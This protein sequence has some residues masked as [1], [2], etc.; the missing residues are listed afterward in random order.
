MYQ[1]HPEMDI[2]EVVQNIFLVVDPKTGK[3][4]R[5]SPKKVQLEGSYTSKMY[6]SSYDNRVVVQGNPSKWNRRDNLFGIK[7]IDECVLIINEILED[8]GLPP[9]T[10]NETAKYYQSPE[11]KR[12]VR[13]ADGAIFTRADWTTNY[14][15]GKG[16]EQAVLRALSTQAVG[17][18]KLPHHYPNGM[19]TEW[20]AGSQF[21]YL[22]AYNK[23]HEMARL[24]KKNNPT[25]EDR[26]Y[27]EKLIKHCENTGIVRLELECKSKFLKRN[28]LCYYGDTSEKH[29]M[30]HLYKIEQIWEKLQMN[31]HKYESISDQLIKR[32]ICT[33]TQSANS[34]QSY[35]YQWK[36]GEVL[37]KAKSQY[38]VHRSR[39]MQ[40]GID[41]AIPHDPTKNM[42]EI[43][44]SKPV[45]VR[46][47]MPPTWYEMPN[48]SGRNIG[49]SA[50][51]LH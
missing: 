46:Y 4:E 44:L 25:G 5:S 16:N 41:I 22:K 39:L 28:N 48:A 8:N 42:P 15:V 51:A 49:V 14:E 21:W 38:H 13:V 20:G 6:I 32:E 45:Q 30:P 23:A 29:F 1:D 36:Y 31:P 9:F 26:K 11:D 27:L 24:L 19:T 40:I 35:W 50:G 37:D 33:N 12:S 43:E 3:V 17:R 10:K 18:A 34:T 7:S 2:R 47:S